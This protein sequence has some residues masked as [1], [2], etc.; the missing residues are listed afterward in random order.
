MNLPELAFHPQGGVMSALVEIPRYTDG[1]VES[2]IEPSEIEAKMGPFFSEAM[3]KMGLPQVQLI[4]NGKPYEFKFSLQV[5]RNKYYSIWEWTCVT[6]L[7]V[8]KMW[9]HF[10]HGCEH[11]DIELTFYAYKMDLSQS[12]YMPLQL[13]L[14]VLNALP[15]I[16]GR[17]EY[18]NVHE[19]DL[20]DTNMMNDAGGVRYQGALIPVG[21]QFKDTETVLAAHDGPAMI[22]PLDDWAAEW[23]PY[24]TPAKGKHPDVHLDMDPLVNR[25][26]ILRSRAGGTGEQFGFGMWKFLDALEQRSMT[27]LYKESLAVHQ[28]VRR[29]NHYFEPSGAIFQAK[30]HPKYVSWDERVHYNTNVSPDRAYRLGW[31]NPIGEDWTGEDDQHYSG[32]AISEHV[33]LTG[34]MA[35][36]FECEHKAQHALAKYTW[37]TAG[38]ACGRYIPGVMSIA[39]V[40]FVGDLLR[41]RLKVWAE[42]LVKEFYEVN[43]V[44]DVTKLMGMRLFTNDG[45]TH[46]RPVELILW[47]DAI[48]INGIMVGAKSLENDDVLSHKLREVAYYLVSSLAQFALNP[49]DNNRI[50]KAMKWDGKGTVYTEWDNT[51]VCAD[52]K[53]TAYH[54][55]GLPAWHLAKM[56]AREFTDPILAAKA[57]VALKAIDKNYINLSSYEGAKDA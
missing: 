13:T 8:G 42:R 18:H 16:Y 5:S 48:A 29:I 30:K 10:G 4:V 52:A 56:L 1:P 34:S 31:S 37:P 33:L 40:S 3:E 53:N 49:L 54:E 44:P 28:E 38:R 12:I 45:N 32:I 11:L 21:V 19:V 50:G 24:G 39:R 26:Y 25:G 15:R 35:S 7:G 43:P 47:E 57:E 41:A 9:T 55:W 27:L 46:I 22:C 17:E 20:L 51:L 36:R 14:Q 6:P 23:G 2:V